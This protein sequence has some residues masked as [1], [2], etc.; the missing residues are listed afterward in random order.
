M[1]K[2]ILR[3]TRCATLVIFLAACQPVATVEPTAT[4]S[5]PVAPFITVAPAQA[6]PG[7]TVTISGLGWRAG[8]QVSLFVQPVDPAQG[9]GLAGGSLLADENGQFQFVVVLPGD[10]RPGAWTITA[11]G[12][13]PER[14][15]SVS[16]AVVAP[17][18]Q[19]GTL[20]TVTPTASP[21]SLA[22]D[23]PT[24]A[25]PV[26]TPTHTRPPRPNTPVPPMVTATPVP[27][28][29]ITDWRGDYFNNPNLAGNPALIR[30]DSNINFDW[31]NGS[32]DPQI[33][34]DGFSTRWT[35]RLYFDPGLYRFTLRVDDGARLFVN[36]VL[37]IDEW[38]DGALRDVSTD[39]TLAAGE[40]DLRIEYYERG[41]RAA[42]AL[43]Y[44]RVSFTPTS[45]P[46]RTP[47][48]ATATSAPLPSPTPSVTPIPL[49]TQAPAPTNTPRPTPIPLPTNTPTR[50]PTA[51]PT[52]TPIP[53]FTAT[54][55]RTPAPPTPTPTERPTNTPVPPTATPT[56]TEPPTNTPAPPTATPTPTE[57]P[58]NTP[59]PPTATPT[60]TEPPTNTPEPPTPTATPPELP[61][62]TPTP[63]PSPTVTPTT[64]A[65]ATVTLSGTVLLVQGQNWP[66]GGRVVVSISASATG[67]DAV[68]VGEVRTNRRGVVSGQIQLREPLEGDQYAVLRSGR[69]RL[70][71]P[72]VRVPSS[73]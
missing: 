67:E 9:V 56:P 57:P 10:M 20:V 11:R 53:D 31:G 58:T 21:T 8:E 52:A 1:I 39:L 4:V 28:P 5:G 72:I 33:N 44:V 69:V 22:V 37:V 25:P 15:A 66:A 3:L 26:P 71:V 7:Q 60:P 51:T 24:A 61:T 14:S 63:L 17:T 45:T 23:T 36:G 62:E 49:P 32:P 19:P 59:A 70:I 43:T 12:A 40:H 68:R 30:N 6:A 16:F 41:G 46:S 55:T 54:P 29:V 13:G 50:V 18:L 64:G 73:E 47:A 42:I 38:R 65:T 34:A 35:R 2:L 48:P 27:L